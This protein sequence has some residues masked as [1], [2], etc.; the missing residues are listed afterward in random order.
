MKIKVTHRYSD[1]SMSRIMSMIE[2]AANHKSRSESLL[3]RITR[4]YTPAVMIAA[5]LLFA[6]PWA[7]SLINGTYFDWHVWFERALVLLVCSC[8]CALIVSI[9]LSYFAAIG[10]ASKFGVLFK[11]SSYLDSLRQCDS[12]LLDKTGTI[13]TGN[14]EVIKAIPTPG[15]TKENLVALA[16]MVEADSNHPLAKAICRCGLPKVPNLDISKIT[17]V[18]H[19]IVADTNMGKLLVGS[20]KLMQANNI[21]LSDSTS[22]EDTEVC[23]SLNGEFIGSIVLADTLKPGIAET[24]LQL[25]RLGVKS[26]GILSGDNER[27]VASAAR[28]AGVDFHKSQ[29]LPA[30]K[31]LF[32]MKRVNNGRHTIFIGDGINDAP[33]LAAAT[34]GIAIGTGGSDIAMQSADAVIMGHDLNHLVDAMKLSRRLRAVVAENVTLAIG[35]KLAVMILGAMGIA[36]LW[37]AVFADTGIMV[38]TVLWTMIA[39]RPR[40]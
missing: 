18:N 30:D 15:H 5:I 31:Q 40:K 29:L 32:I 14:F 39:L 4:W 10:A 26:I 7:L 33:S 3:R 34:V 8:P 37:A 6:V 28:Q 36:S 1:S 11:G 21:D 12:L 22:V 13:T 9:P 24:L 19:G 20:R 23:V 16:S 17:E 35:V 27:A 38:I 2:D 25:R